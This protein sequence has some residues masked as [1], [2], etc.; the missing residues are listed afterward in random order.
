M[1]DHLK[2]AL[3]K[4]LAGQRHR[5]YE[6]RVAEQALSY[7][8][9]LEQEMAKEREEIIAWK[10]VREESGEERLSVSV[11]SEENFC[12]CVSDRKVKEKRGDIW[13]VTSDKMALTETADLEAER[14][15]LEHPTC[16]IA[17][18]DEDRY[19]KP[20]WSPDLL[21][22][23]FYFGNV[24]AVRKT[25]V[26]EIVES[27]TALGQEPPAEGEINPAQE[28]LSRKQELYRIVL[29][30]IDTAKEAGHIEKIL[31]RTEKTEGT[32]GDCR[33][34]SLTLG[35]YGDWGR[36]PIFDAVK[37]GHLY[38]DAEVP[39]KREE[40]ELVSVI[41]PTKDQPTLLSK[42]IRS[43]WERTAYGNMEIIVVDN[44]SN[45]KNKNKIL[46]MRDQLRE[47]YSFRYVYRPMPF[48]FSA[49]CNLGAGE[50][51]G[52]YLLFL[53]DDIEIYEKNW[54]RVMAAK[55]AKEYVGAVGAKLLYPNSGRIQHLGIANIHLGPTHKLQ[56][57][58]DEKEHYH[59]YNRCA[60]NVSAVTGACLLVRRAVFE[61][62]GGF[63]EKLQVAFNDV[64][65]CFR[66]L[67][68]GYRNVCCNNTFLYH[69]ESASR[70]QDAG[71]EKIDRLH[72][73]RDLLYAAYPEMWNRDAYYSAKLVRDIQDKGFEAAN[74][75]EE[76]RLS[77]RGIP[78]RRTER[79]KQAWHNESLQMGFEFTGDRRAW[80]TGRSGGGDYYIQGWCH[81]P[82]V[83]NSRYKKSL[84]LKP[85][86]E[87]EGQEK[88]WWKVP[89]EGCSR[90][91]FAENLPAAE[92]GALC[93]V[94]VWIP[95]EALPGGE[96]L[97]G[98]L[99]ED[100]CS[101]QRLY[102]FSGEKLTV[103]EK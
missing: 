48:N 15:F 69:H 3:Q 86:K 1:I 77:G 18:G 16:M 30:C 56:F 4:L 80:E 58:S 43:L 41:I 61:E 28:A 10:R 29:G 72:R 88:I 14:Y 57:A 70:G 49:L 60:V 96:Y 55:A 34:D 82:G 46:Q 38:S 40:Q 84:L 65:F 92:Y 74:R 73:E 17:Y 22:S 79:L 11:L 64:E 19:L 62:A 31:F 9:W 23:F 20:G 8:V 59:G 94:S 45:E 33:D 53:N 35:K 25:L 51:K 95:R 103:E 5:Q 68:A 75:F 87:R 13:L 50:A 7:A 97:I 78:E 21:Q 90:P 101:R 85:L 83:D 37:R 93:G 76:K 81:V 36:D 100:T 71:T 24:F 67:R 44:G 47:E 102:R 52:K 98:G 12:E 2:R 99:W 32:A 89:Y 63:S 26:E 91:D 27:V 42:C 54:L 66:L 6:R 39:K